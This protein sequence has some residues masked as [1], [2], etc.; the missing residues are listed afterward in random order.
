MGTC[1]RRNIPN[2]LLLHCHCKFLPV[3][4]YTLA[5]VYPQIYTIIAIVLQLHKYFL[6]FQPGSFYSRHP[7]NA[8]QHRAHCIHIPV[9]PRSNETAP[10]HYCI[11][12]HYSSKPGMWPAK[13]SRLASDCICQ[14]FSL[15]LQRMIKQ[16]TNTTWAMICMAPIR[17]SSASWMSCLV[18]VLG[19]AALVVS[20]K[21][22]CL[23]PSLVA[24]V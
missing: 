23:A 3:S 21:D 1:E 6:P 17:C 2:S 18:Q 16:H 5:F 10:H 11:G 4:L 9:R 15:L 13:P 24:E 19:G 14:N 20:A 8:Q 12:S 22:R 7:Q